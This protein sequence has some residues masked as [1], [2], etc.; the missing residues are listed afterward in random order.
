MPNADAISWFAEIARSQARI[1]RIPG[2]PRI[3]EIVVGFPQVSINGVDNHGNVDVTV[4]NV[5]GCSNGQGPNFVG[6]PVFGF[7]PVPVRLIRS[8]W[9]RPALTAATTT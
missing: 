6:N 4:L 2:S 7:S 3:A 1:P 5:A 8:P 9:F